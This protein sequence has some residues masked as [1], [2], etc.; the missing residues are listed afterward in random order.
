[1]SFIA[2]VMSYVLWKVIYIALIIT[3]VC[4]YIVFFLSSLLPVI[5]L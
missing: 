2:D 5:T 4:S 3:T 1:M